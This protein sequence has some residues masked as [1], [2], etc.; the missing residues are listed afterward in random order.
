MFLIRLRSTYY[1]PLSTLPATDVN[2]NLC[3]AAFPVVGCLDGPTEPCMHASSWP[4]FQ[5]P[6]VH[7]LSVHVLCY[8]LAFCQCP[9]LQNQENCNA[10]AVTATLAPA[11]PL[12]TNPFTKIAIGVVAD[13]H[14]SIRYGL[15]NQRSRRHRSRSSSGLAAPRSV[16]V[17]VVS[18]ASSTFTWTDSPGAAP[19]AGMTH[20]E[21]DPGQKMVV[22]TCGAF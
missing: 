8:E 9:P 2:H 11:F 1:T 19:R 7:H 15:R 6:S 3:T 18:L 12:K 4:G 20:D 14:I 16:F 17:V 10:S 5:A 21:H 22:R 13:R